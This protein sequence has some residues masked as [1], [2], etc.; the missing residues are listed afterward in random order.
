MKKLLLFLV[1]I[2]SIDSFAQDGSLDTAFGDGGIVVTDLNNSQD[3]VLNVVQQAD[4]KLIVSGI[5]ISDADDYY[6]YLIRYMPDGTIDTSFGTNGK[7]FSD[8]EDSFYDYKY[9]FVDNEQHILAAGPMGQSS[10][11]VI[12]KYL[13]NGN[14]D[15]TFGNN[16]VVSIPNGNY[17]AMTFMDDGSMLLLKFTGNEEVIISHYFPDGVLDTSYGINGAAS[18]NFS[19][20]NFNASELKIDLDNNIYLVGTRDNN[21]NADIILMRGMDI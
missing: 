21:A 15:S 20:G 14:L 16:G 19:G 3:L 10:T 4:Q 17:V 18:S 11:F 13:Y 12:A 5:M 6:P 7:V 1:V 2:V 8:N 9:L